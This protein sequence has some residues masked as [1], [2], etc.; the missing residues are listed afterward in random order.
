[1]ALYFIILIGLISGVA[2]GLQ[3][4]FASLISQKLGMLES[5]FIV[6]VGGMIVSLVPLIF[7]GGGQ[8]RNWNSLPWY[9]LGAGAFGLIVISGI[10]YMI[11]RVGVAPAFLI[12]ILGQVLMGTILDHFGL[13]GA[14]V[15]PFD[16]VK[17]AGLGI[18]LFGVWL[19]VR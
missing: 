8:L 18:A 10:S 7:L 5:V 9:T 6:H 11:P 13:F 16:W 14:V 17:L 19:A 3:G 12:L 4:P 2:V 15:R 1:M